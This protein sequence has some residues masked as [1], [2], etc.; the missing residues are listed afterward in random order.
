MTGT[1]DEHEAE[2]QHEHGVG[3][4]PNEPVGSADA[5]P[6]AERVR[7][8]ERERLRA[9][10]AA[11]MDA[12]ERLHVADFLLINPAGA[13]LSREQYLGWVASGE[14]D[15]RVWKPDSPIEVRLYALHCWKYYWVPKDIPSEQIDWSQ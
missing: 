9:L 12:A 7:A 5:V 11:D 15:Y 14:I 8:T 13:V 10:V 2:S 3:D 6:E 4:L 1:S